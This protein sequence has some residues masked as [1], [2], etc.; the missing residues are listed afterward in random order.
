TIKRLP[1][2]A[3]TGKYSELIRDE[4]TITFIR[5]GAL[6]TFFITR[7]S[8]TEQLGFINAIK[9]IQAD[10]NDKKISIGKDYYD[11]F[12]SNNAAFD[13]MLIEEDEI[14]TEKAMISGN[15]AKIIKILKAMK[16][17]PELTDD[18]EDKIEKMIKLWEN[19]EIPS[20]VSKDVVKKMKITTSVL[21]LYYEIL[22]LTPPVYFEEKKTCTVKEDGEKHIILSC[23]LR[24][25]GNK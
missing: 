17:A 25:G 9:Y 16:V 5:K 19:G 18:Q 8:G 2:K 13:N 11:H 1:K 6:K 3:K 22:K 24:N 12:D 10:I 14:T 23:F 20:K 21:E 15:D 7:G 4:S